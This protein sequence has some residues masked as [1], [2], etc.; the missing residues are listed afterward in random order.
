MFPCRGN[1][2][3]ADIFACRALN[4]KL[5]THDDIKYQIKSSRVLNQRFFEDFVNAISKSFANYKQ[6][7]NGFI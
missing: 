4:L 5:I 6:A 3:C 2:W 7:N 1:R